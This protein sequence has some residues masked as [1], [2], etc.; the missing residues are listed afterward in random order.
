MHTIT[1]KNSQVSSFMNDVSGLFLDIQTPNIVL[2]RYSKS[3][4][5]CQKKHNHLSKQKKVACHKQPV[6]IALLLRLIY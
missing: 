1:E 3:V 5:F 4:F 2:K 6:L